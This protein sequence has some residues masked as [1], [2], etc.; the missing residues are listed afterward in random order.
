VKNEKEEEHGS[1][2]NEEREG[3]TVRNADGED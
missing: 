2:R 1:K 3:F